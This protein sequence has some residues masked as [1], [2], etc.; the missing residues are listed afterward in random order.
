M[1]VAVL[2]TGKMAAALLRGWVTSGA[3]SPTDVRLANRTLARA[4]ALAD[5]IKSLS[6]SRKGAPGAQV[7]RPTVCDTFAE[8]VVNADLV[9][10]SVKPFAVVE[11]LRAIQDALDPKALIVSVAAGIRLKTMEDALYRAQPIIRVM[12]NTPA[13]IGAAASAFCSGRNATPDHGKRVRALFSSV[14]VCV[15]VTEEQIDAVIGVSGSGVA[16]LYLII[17]ALTDGGVR[18]GLPR[19]VARALAAQTVVGAGRMVLETGEHPA[20]LKDAVTTPGG[21][22][23]TALE[24]L[25]R[26]GI[27][28]TLIE[29][30]LAARDRAR[31]LA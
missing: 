22:T 16:Y 19:D 8:A 17:E 24:V 4:I 15:E 12:P 7:G 13:A 3:V 29:A 21:T 20:V 31:E 26:A 10:V 30:V 14:G 2:G 27:R 28:G 11:C 18:A 6:T 23:I 5:E 25:E 1:K 9:L